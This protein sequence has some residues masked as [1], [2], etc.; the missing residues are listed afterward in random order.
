MAMPPKVSKAHRGKRRYIG[1]ALEPLDEGESEL[2]RLARSIQ[3][4]RVLEARS[5]DP[6]HRI[7]RVPLASYVHAREAL[8]EEFGALT[9]ITSSGKIGL[10]RTRL[11]GAG[12]VDD[13]S[14]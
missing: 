2:R 1:L 11:I 4:S 14:E 10:V 7:L 5:Q 6:S 9:S 3:G 12:K 13:E 8:Q